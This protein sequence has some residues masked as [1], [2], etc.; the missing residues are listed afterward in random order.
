MRTSK[1]VRACRGGGEESDRLV[2]PSAREPLSLSL[3]MDM[4][5]ISSWSKKDK[6]EKKKGSLGEQGDEQSC[7]EGKD[8][9]KICVLCHQSL[10]LLQTVMKQNLFHLPACG[11]E[12]HHG[13]F[14][15]DNRD[16]LYNLPNQNYVQSRTY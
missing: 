11:H 13:C 15:A 16:Q 4:M 10:T 3:L 12:F 14:H 5:Q 1:N 8:M 6:I 9:N 7:R 2:M